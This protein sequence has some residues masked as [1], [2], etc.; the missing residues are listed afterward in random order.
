MYEN[1]A[2][3]LRNLAI[4]VLSQTE[5]SSTCERNLSTFALIHTKQ[6]NRLA[7]PR[8]QQLV[9]CYYN[10]KLKIRDMQAETDKVAKK[11]YLDL[12][13]ISTELVKKRIINYFNGLDLSIWMMKMK[14]LIHELLHMFKKHVLMLTMFYL[15]KFI[16]KVSVKKRETHFS[17]LLLLDP[18][19]IQ[20][21]NIVVDL[22]LSVLLLQVMMTQEVRRPMMVVILEMMVG[23][24]QIDK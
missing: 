21:L 6:R 17:P 22:V 4:K 5:F 9:F 11:N 24:L 7:C 20:V 16:V 19:L 2:P 10:M 3:T 1:H 14:I 13:G 15:K 8:L 18:L 12:L 23:I